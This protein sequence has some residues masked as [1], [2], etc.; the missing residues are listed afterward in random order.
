MKN[1]SY[2]FIN[3]KGNGM[4]Y[5][6]H[7]IRL[8][9]LKLLDDISFT[10]YYKKQ[11][12]SNNLKKELISLCSQKSTFLCSDASLTVPYKTFKS[13]KRFMIWEPYDYI[14]QYMLDEPTKKKN[15]SQRGFTQICTYGPAFTRAHKKNFSRFGLISHNIGLPATMDMHNSDFI[16]KNRSDLEKLYPQLAG[17]KILYLYMNLLTPELDNF[18][19]ATTLLNNLPNDWILVTRSGF[20]KEY[21][22]TLPNFSTNKMLILTE[23]DITSYLL[24]AAADMLISDNSC[25]IVYY[26]ASE[27]PFFILQ[28]NS[29]S[30][31]LKY[32]REKYSDLEVKNFEQIKSFLTDCNI[33]DIHKNFIKEHTNTACKKNIVQKLI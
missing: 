10:F 32:I 17:K 2:S 15:K 11:D 29:K 22:N 28:G 27:R 13:F 3:T 9:L 16:A 6:E 30:H 33:N 24:L 5:N 7:Q 20:L 12:S 1:K 25:N 26:A 8:D 23:S 14:F 19:F 31:F 4:T 18:Q 21:A